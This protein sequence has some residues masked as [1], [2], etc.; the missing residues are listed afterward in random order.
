MQRFFVFYAH[1]SCCLPVAV[2]RHAPVHVATRVVTAVVVQAATP[3]AKVVQT[4]V[5]AIMAKPG[6]RNVIKDQMNMR[7]CN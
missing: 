5:F 1:Q 7:S 2:I 3:A 4:A 6:F